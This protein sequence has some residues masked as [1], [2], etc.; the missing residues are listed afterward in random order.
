MPHAAVPTD[1][2]L[3]RD[4][5]RIASA[6]AALD[7]FAASRPP[8]VLGVRLELG[9]VADQNVGLTLHRDRPDIPSP[10]HIRDRML[11]RVDLSGPSA[12]VS[13]LG[14]F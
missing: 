14:Q 3:A 12:A 13:L 9:Y 8:F 11:G 5:A 2:A 6:G 4:G 7:L 1:I 10:L